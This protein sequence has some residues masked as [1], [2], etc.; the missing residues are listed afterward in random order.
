MKQKQMKT[1]YL[2]PITCTMRIN[3]DA[4]FLTGS[5]VDATSGNGAETGAYWT[6]ESEELSW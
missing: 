1:K 3:L 4:Q 6:Y 2:C 5:N